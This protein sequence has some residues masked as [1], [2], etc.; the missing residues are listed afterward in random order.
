MIYFIRHGESIG[1]VDGIIQGSLDLGLTEKGMEQAGYL[2][3]NLKDKSITK[4]ITSPLIRATQTSEI[5]NNEVNTQ[6]IFDER[7]KEYCYG[8]AEGKPWEIATTKY[9]IQLGAW[10]LGDINNEEGPNLF[11]ER[12]DSFLHDIQKQYIDQNVICVTHGAVVSRIACSIMGLDITI[13]PHIRVSNTSV[14]LIDNQSNNFNNKLVIVKINDCSHLE[15]V[16]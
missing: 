3:K 4:I 5:I 13:R 12:I 11:A 15:A 2:S 16:S 14:M 1:N 7:L 6:I 10:G 8:D 9:G